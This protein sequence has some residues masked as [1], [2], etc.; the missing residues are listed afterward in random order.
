MVR[1]SVIIPAYN[2]QE[3]IIRCLN[4]VYSLPVPEDDFEVIVIDDC[5]TDCTVDVIREFKA[6]HPNLTLL[7]QSENHRQG[8]ARNRGVNLARGEYIVFLDSD[9]EIESGVLSACDLSREKDLDMVVMRHEKLSFDGNL[10][11]E[12]VLPYASDTVFSG[13]AFQT[14]YPYWC[15]APWAYLFRRL[16]L[17]RI[18][19]PFAEDVLYE[20][21]D[22]VS[23]H[24]FYAERMAFCDECGYRMWSNPSSVTHTT[25]FK[26]VCDYAVLG[27]RMLAFYQRLKDKNDLYAKSILEGGSYNIMRSCKSLFK[28]K[29]FSEVCS[30]YTRFDE[31]AKRSA[32]LSYSEPAYCWNRW[33]RFCLKHRFGTILIV[34]SIL[35]FNFLPLMKRF[36]R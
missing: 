3:T 14:E 20:D 23:V 31:F 12:K 24:L 1:L 25:S 19:Y 32:L 16:F 4:S 26:H 11:R 35:S 10:E 30:F 33:T 2:A 22:F 5:S 13:V 15:T 36:L 27:T 7:V 9:D 18:N 34:G 6:V 17:K 28:L 21:S 8:A 29:S